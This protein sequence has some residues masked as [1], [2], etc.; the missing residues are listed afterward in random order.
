ME[1]LIGHIERLLLL[2]DCVI[3]PDFGGFVL[4]GVSSVH[5]A[6]TN[7]FFPPHKEV[8]FNQTLNHNDGLLIESYMKSYETDFNKAQQLVRNDVSEMKETLEDEG[9]LEFGAIGLFL[10]DEERL[11]FMAGK[12]SEHLY[13]TSLYGLPIF[14][15]LPLA[16]R[17]SAV[18]PV[19]VES[20]TEKTEKV[21]ES[22][23]KDILYKIPITRT[24]VRAAAAVAAAILIFLLVS[25]PVRDVNKESYKASFVPQEIMPKKTVEDVLNE[26]FDKTMGQEASIKKQELSSAVNQESLLAS[27]NLKPEIKQPITEEKSE[28]S[29]TTASKPAVTPTSKPAVTPTAKTDK[30]ASDKPA[31]TKETTSESKKNY[32]VVIGSFDTTTQANRYIKSLKGQQKGAG[33]ISSDGHIRVYAQA[34]VTEKS[35]N[36]YMNNLRKNTKHKQAWVYKVKN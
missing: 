25:T 10:K 36:S 9:E 32:Y 3:I 14:H 35:A 23:Q 2:H 12:G 24:L 21:E 33:I 1:K 17:R 31:S 13:S 26:A 15:F 16:N 5:N 7:M 4:Q 29:E 28:K 18:S 34:F 6:E 19:T 30:S 11:I 8:V 20:R 27:N 22:E